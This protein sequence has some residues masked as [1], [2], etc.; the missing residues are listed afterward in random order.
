MQC[1]SQYAVSN[2]VD[3]FLTHTS[4]GVFFCKREISSSIRL[5][6]KPNAMHAWVDCRSGIDNCMR[7][8]YFWLRTNSGR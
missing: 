6:S 3:V 5:V 7:A 1:A 4:Q 2:V 8:Y